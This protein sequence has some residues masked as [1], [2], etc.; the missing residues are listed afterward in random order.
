[1]S[2]AW[3]LLI[4][5]ALLHAVW[6]AF[7]KNSSDKTH[8][9]PGIILVAV[10][11]S[12][13]FLPLAEGIYYTDLHSIPYLVI[14]GI[15]EG[16]YLFTLAWA[17]QSASLGKTY[18][19]IRGA[20]M[21]L[22]WL[23]SVTFLSEKFSWIAFLGVAVMLL[24]LVILEGKFWRKS[25]WGMK[26]FLPYLCALMIT[27]YHLSYG[28]ALEAGIFP[29]A[30]FCGSLSVGLLVYLGLIG[31]Q[32]GGQSVR[33]FKKHPVALTLAGIACAG[34][35]LLFLYGL[36]QSMPGVAITVRNTSV[37]F[38]QVLALFLGERF[39]RNHWIAV[40]L[41]MLGAMAF[42]IP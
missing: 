32:N 26:D 3:V 7:L 2:T 12:A 20:A 22:V 16:I 34:S 29:P 24:G 13:L 5:S 30:L 4:A 40:A 23:L 21:I 15:C 41:I 42:A 19:Q 27:G 38:A 17:F 8:A 10:V 31:F 9:M 33:Y 11:T 14:A 6:N 28:K 36:S 35:F 37:G 25:S 18:A 39:N 1:M